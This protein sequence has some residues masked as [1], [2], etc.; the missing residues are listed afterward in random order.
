MRRGNDSLE[1]IIV[2]GN[3]EG[4]RPRGRSPTRW[5]NHLVG[6]IEKIK[7]RPLLSNRQNGLQQK[8]M[9]TVYQREVE[10]SPGP[11]SSVMKERPERERD[12]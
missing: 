3:T 10:I 7:F 5:A 11:R 12:I 1:K 9:E 6:D 2:T 8:P 4:K